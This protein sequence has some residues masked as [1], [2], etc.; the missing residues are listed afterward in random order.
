M[1][2][3][4]KVSKKNV[5]HCLSTCSRALLSICW[6]LDADLPLL[7]V[8]SRRRMLSNELTCLVFQEMVDVFKVEVDGCI[9]DSV[10]LLDAQ[11]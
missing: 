5:Q 1:I 6:S 4:L 9:L 11:K 3:Y 7:D 2:N 8:L 10:S